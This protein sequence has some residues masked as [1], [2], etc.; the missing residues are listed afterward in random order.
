MHFVFFF[1]LN[2][3]V[4]HLIW[5]KFKIMLDI[6]FEKFDLHV[7]RRKLN[8]NKI[9]QNIARS[10]ACVYRD[11]CRNSWRKEML[12]LTICFSQY[13]TSFFPIFTKHHLWNHHFFFLNINDVHVYQVIFFYITHLK[14]T[15]KLAEKN[16]CPISRWI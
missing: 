10:P 9:K 11:V 1:F 6:Y 2:L 12:F 16:V 4:F 14:L 7:W 13:L 8:T 15:K 3:D 5:R